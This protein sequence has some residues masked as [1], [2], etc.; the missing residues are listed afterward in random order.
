M[1]VETPLH[2]L[3]LPDRDHHQVEILLEA[4]Q[5]RLAALHDRSATRHV[6]IFKNRGVEAGTSLEHPHS[7]IVCLDFVP[8]EVMR[9]VQVA[10]RFHRKTGGCVLCTVLG[11]ERHTGLRIVF[12]ADG[13]VA[14]APYASASAGEMLLV[15]IHH[16]P[17][18]VAASGGLREGLGRALVLL[19]DRCR[20]AFGD[21]PYNLVLH[22][23]PKRW[24]QDPG[25]HWFWQLSPRLTRPAGFE[26]GTGVGINTLAPEDAASVLR[27]PS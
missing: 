4:F 5:Q 3:E 20:T 16:A 9:R 23:A 19:L 13:F 26:I 22:T 10:R 21:P 15:P 11:E 18:F 12:E 14:F 1:V 25:L 7:Q 8:T 2:N 6:A 27:S 17:S 24:L